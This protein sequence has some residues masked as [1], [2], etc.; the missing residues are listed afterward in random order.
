MTV[1]STE[2]GDGKT[3]LCSNLA[4]LYSM[5]GKKTLLVDADIRKPNLHTKLGLEDGLGLTNYLIGDCELDDIIVTDTPF[6]F[7]LMLAGTVPPNPGELIHS[8]KMAEMLQNLRERYSY[9]IIDTSPIGLVPDA[10]PLIDQSDLCLFV[11]RCMQTDK[12]LCKLTLEQMAEVV[13]N[14]EKVQIVLSDIPIEGRF[15][16]GGYGYGYGYGYGGYGYGYGGYGY[17]AYG[18]GKRRRSRFSK[19]NQ[20]AI[21]TYNYYHDD[22]EEED[23]AETETNSKK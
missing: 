6:G 20:D 2:S 5:T 14:Q 18:Y 19:R 9:I 4:A 21:N 7:D 13:E 23:N 16:Y 10:Y 12:G 8:D 1:S 3:F 11:V 22:E 17:G 15:S